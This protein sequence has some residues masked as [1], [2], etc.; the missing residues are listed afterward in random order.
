LVGNKVS[1]IDAFAQF[2]TKVIAEPWVHLSV[3]HVNGHDFLCAP[4]QQAVGETAR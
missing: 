4:L 3:P 1:G 2:D